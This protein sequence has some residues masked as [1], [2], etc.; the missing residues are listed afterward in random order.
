MFS[1]IKTYAMA[2]LAILAAILFGLWNWE[3]ARRQKERA[4]GLINQR[5]VE[6][7]GTDAL[8]KGMQ[9]ENEETNKPVDTDERKHFER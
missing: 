2:T 9:K 6:R 7:K 8:V 4:K 1:T 3:K 5:K